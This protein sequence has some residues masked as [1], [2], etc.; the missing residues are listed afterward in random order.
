MIPP[1]KE[2]L[3]FFGHCHVSYP[4]IDP[5]SFFGRFVQK[6]TES[7]FSDSFCQFLSQYSGGSHYATNNP[8]ILQKTLRK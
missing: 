3:S 5:L 1:Y 8:Q 2:I 7:C 4:Y 6:V